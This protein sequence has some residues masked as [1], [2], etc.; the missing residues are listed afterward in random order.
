M[1]RARLRSVI[2]ASVGPYALIDAT[3]LKGAIWFRG[4][5]LFCVGMNRNCL[6][7][8]RL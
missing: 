4:C 7:Q 5:L 1:T 3:P 2:W 8:S 6:Q